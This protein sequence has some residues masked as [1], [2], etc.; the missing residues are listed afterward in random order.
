MVTAFGVPEEPLVKQ[1]YAGRP[2]GVGRCH[3]GRAGATPATSTA[4]RS[5][6]VV[7]WGSGRTPGPGSAAG[8]PAAAA[9]PCR[10]A[11][12]SPAAIGTDPR[13]ARR[14]ASTAASGRRG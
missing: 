11:A 10:P 12:G 14:T 3:R 2:A 4:L 1:V 9:S 8:A 13:P 5:T 7:T 6:V